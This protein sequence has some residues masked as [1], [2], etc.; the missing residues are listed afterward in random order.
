M[1][2]NVCNAFEKEKKKI[3]EDVYNGHLAEI[4]KLEDESIYLSKIDL[5]N[6]LYEAI[7]GNMDKFVKTRNTLKNAVDYLQEQKMIHMIEFCRQ[8]NSMITINKII[9]NDRFKCIKE[10]YDLCNQ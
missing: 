2:A 9:N 3:Q 5:E 1:H 4:Q 8:L 7:P 6:D 10:L